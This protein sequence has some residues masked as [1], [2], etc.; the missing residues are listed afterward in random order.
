M[1]ISDWSSDVCSSDLETS[2]Q[3]EELGTWMLINVC[4]EAVTWPTAVNV[5][6]AVSPKWFSSS[7]LL[8]QVRTALE[9]SGLAPHRLTLAVAE[10]VL[11]SDHKTVASTLQDRKSVVE[12]KS[13]AVR[14][15]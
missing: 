3:L 2:G 1:R 5:S 4:E 7:F 11:L 14:V 8:K 9:T 13:V 10:G 6:I 15:N 12:G